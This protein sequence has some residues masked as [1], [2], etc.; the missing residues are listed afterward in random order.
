MVAAAP[1]AAHAMGV[2][3]PQRRD[4]AMPV[5]TYT[6]LLRALARRA[7]RTATLDDRAHVA[8]VVFRDGRRADVRYPA[9]DATLPLRMAKAGVEVRIA[10]GSAGLLTYLTPL[11][12]I[13]LLVMAAVSV[14]RRRR[15]HTGATASVG[16]R[17]IVGQRVDVGPVSPKTRFADVAGCDEA[18]E[19]LAEIVEFLRTPERFALVDARMPAGLLLSGPPGTGKTMLARALAGEAG[20]RFYAASAS[21]FVEKFV[22]VGASRVRDVFRRALANAPAVIFIDELD[23][24]GGSRN[25]HD[26][27]SEREQTLNELLV[28]MDGFVASDHV[29]VVGAT[30][31]PDVLDDA[32][33]R[34]GRF[35]RQISVGLPSVEGREAILGV[36]GA[37]K[38]FAQ[39]VDL[40][41]IAAMTGGFSGAQL[42]EL[43][44]EAA[45][46][47]ARE[48]RL[49]IEAADVREGLRRVIA[50]PRRR[51]APIGAGELEKIA[52]HEAGH[53]VCAELC[54]RHENAQHVTIDPRGQ[55]MG[56]ALFG[57]ED[58]A[59]YDEEHLHDAMV[60]ALGGRAA[61][62]LVFGR[63]S[64]GAKNDLEK[65]SV[66][67]RTAVTEYGM[68]S[69]IG[70]FAG[71]E[72]L[73]SNQ[74]RA[75]IDREVERLV[76]AA[77][78]DS[79][80]LLDANRPA[81]DALAARLL[82]ARELERID[83]VTALS[84]FGRERVAAATAVRWQP[85][86]RSW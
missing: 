27:N 56:F 51:S 68:T 71:D 37:S 55:A 42:A 82:D 47:A 29:V 30:N 84:P 41:A 26:G 50:G 33:L 3:L 14:H 9:A 52:Y 78:G 67:A 61:E 8:A 4:A 81:L 58:R 62:Q 66:I 72:R 34:P 11:L 65:A 70:Q 76:A 83:I 15:K 25:G 74:S 12:V 46:M 10:K 85:H 59:L 54:E 13:S 28:Q 48:N 80:T 40:T 23:A 17:T 60:T 18:V 57:H 77:Y 7:I 49:R 6:D 44:N 2:P 43:L 38:P 1:P 86:E 64:S 32:L 73:L 24:I 75:L 36:H 20:V 79:L 31:R 21:E 63:V 16:D 39:D 45:I 5:S 22:G 35:S 53:V 19:E 69:R